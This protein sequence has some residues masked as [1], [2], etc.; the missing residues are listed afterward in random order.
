MSTS[1]N[2]HISLTYYY[3]AK[4]IILEKIKLSLQNSP[5]S[6]AWVKWNKFPDIL[7]NSLTIP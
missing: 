2:I 5:S 4:L 7:Q 3:K 1:Y 6:L